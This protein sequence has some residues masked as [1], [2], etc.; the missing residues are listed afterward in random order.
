LTVLTSDSLAGRETGT[1][2]N[3]KATEYIARYF[4]EIGIPPVNNSY[5]QPIVFSA[6]NFATNKINIKQREYAPM[7]DFYTFPSY[8]TDIKLEEEEV[9]FLGY[10]IDDAR[11]SDYKKINVEG[12]VIL[13]YN[14]EPLKKDSISLITKEKEPSEWSTDITKKIACAKKHGVKAMLI[15]DGDLQKNMNKNRSSYL[16][17]SMKV[18]KNDL[19]RDSFVNASY[20]STTMARVLIDN[21][22]E[23]IVKARDYIIRKGKSKH[24]VLKTQLEINQKKNIRYL[25]GRNVL[26][27][28]EGSDPK[29]KK[30]LVIITA[31]LD[32]LGKRADDIYRG[33]DDDGSG[34]CAVMEIAK[35]FTEAKQKGQGP[36]R[37]VLCMLVTGEEKGLLGSNYYTTYPVFPLKNTVADVN[38]D[39]IG[40]VDAEHSQDPDY[41]YVIGADKISSELHQINEMMN[42][43]YTGLKLDYRY[44]DE[45]D[46]NR[47]YYRSDHY[48]FAKNNI[49]VVF[50]FNGTHE[51]YHRPSDSIEKINFPLLAKRAKLAFYT[52]WEIA[53]REKR[54]KIDKN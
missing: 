42:Q 39:M 16:N 17:T 35:A 40:R 14:G 18:G 50:Y 32:H 53:N 8:N 25:E 9:L 20:I 22:F 1:E 43:N 46:P 21:N 47:Y 51:D 33:A 2:G 30:E 48:N 45:A 52:A 19:I 44:N 24:L 5:F 23:D 4:A 6:E 28:I 15:I 38:I 49:P 26:G 54:L 36:R 34:T 10:G 37:S 31:H 11:Y 7:W 27:Y 13:I 3:L 12:K 29:L 41:I